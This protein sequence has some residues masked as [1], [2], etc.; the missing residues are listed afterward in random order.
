M[1]VLFEV[2]LKRFNNNGRLNMGKDFSV[3]GLGC[4]GE[5]RLSTPGRSR[6]VEEKKAKT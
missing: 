3:P 6:L 2:T 4:L 5:G 1:N